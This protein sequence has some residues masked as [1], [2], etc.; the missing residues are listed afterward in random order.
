MVSLL[1]ILCAATAPEAEESPNAEKATKE[2]IADVW[3]APGA[4]HLPE[5]MPNPVRRRDGKWDVKDYK[6]IPKEE[7][8]TWVPKPLDEAVGIQLRD[9]FE[10]PWK[11]QARLDGIR[12][13]V[14]PAAV[15][16]AKK[17]ERADY[18]TER[19]DEAYDRWTPLEVVLAGAGGLALGFAVG[20]FAGGM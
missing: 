15:E 19:I 14:L 5:G 2:Q 8:G 10:M 1:L 7:D 17:V 9:Y 3:M 20:V 4:K 6:G 18:L 16:Q 12:N 13:K 11:C